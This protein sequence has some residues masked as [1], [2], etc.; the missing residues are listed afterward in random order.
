M[1]GGQ[2]YFIKKPVALIGF[3]GAGKTSVAKLLEE[4][5]GIKSVNTD[6]AVVQVTRQAVSEI[7]NN[8]G[9]EE[10]RKIEAKVLSDIVEDQKVII[11]TGGGIIES[12][13]ARGTLKQCYCV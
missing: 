5:T 3:M 6:K 12:A 7:I 8:Q 1:F 9:E 11:A 2:R 4:H 13:V 10:F